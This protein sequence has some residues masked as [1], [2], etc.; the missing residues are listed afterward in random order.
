MPLVISLHILLFSLSKPSFLYTLTRKKFNRAFTSSIYQ[1][2]HFH[3]KEKMKTIKNTLSGVIENIRDLKKSKN[4]DSFENKRLFLKKI[5]SILNEIK[6]YSQSIKCL[7]TL[8][9]H[10]STDEAL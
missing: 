6:N 1:Q 7:I 5:L 9:L 10:Y 8:L 3:R 2:L 4:K